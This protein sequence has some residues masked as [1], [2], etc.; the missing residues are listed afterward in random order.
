MQSNGSCLHAGSSQSTGSQRVVSVASA[1]AGRFVKY[2]K[3]RQVRFKG[4][5]YTVAWVLVRRSGLYLFLR[6]LGNF[7]PESAVRV[8]DG[9]TAQAHH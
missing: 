9:S 1:L 8:A 5:V 2:N 4:R 3:G 6:E 7:V